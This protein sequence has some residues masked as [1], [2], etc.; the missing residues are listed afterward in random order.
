[1]GLCPGLSSSSDAQMVRSQN[2]NQQ[3]CSQLNLI[4]RKRQLLGIRLAQGRYPSRISQS[5]IL[6]R[7]SWTRQSGTEVRLVSSLGG[8]DDGAYFQ[9]PGPMSNSA[10]FRSAHNLNPEV[11]AT[12][13]SHTSALG[14]PNPLVD[15]AMRGQVE[16]STITRASLIDALTAMLLRVPMTKSAIGCDRIGAVRVTLRCCS[17]PVIN[18]AIL[19]QVVS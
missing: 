10:V 19:H 7:L 4:G 6:N 18:L 2:E 9:A 8:V 17:R 5:E 15:V 11:R 3:P 16:R 12:A 1:M 13:V 14:A